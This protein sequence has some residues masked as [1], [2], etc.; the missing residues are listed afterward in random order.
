MS[1]WQPER[2]F[3][4]PDPPVDEFE[5]FSPIARPE[6]NEELKEINSASESLWSKFPW[7]V[8]EV[9]AMDACFK[10]VVVLSKVFFLDVLSDC[11]GMWPASL[12]F[13]VTMLPISA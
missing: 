12:F 3:S 10:E 5:L 2:I 1:S 8:F 4:F 11:P 9:E 6:M 13:T 7:I